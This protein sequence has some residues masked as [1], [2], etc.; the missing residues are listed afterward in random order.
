PFM[1][2]S[3]F[4]ELPKNRNFSHIRHHRAQQFLHEE[5]YSGPRDSITAV[6]LCVD[7]G[8]RK[9]QLANIYGSPAARRYH[10][11]RAV[12]RVVYLAT[13]AVLA[14]AAMMAAPIV[15]DAF[16]RQGRIAQISQDMLQ[17]QIQYDALT[18]EFPETPIP[19]ETMELAVD[20]YELLGS[21]SRSPQQMLSLISAVVSR[22][23]GVAINSVTWA[24]RGVESEVG[25]TQ[26][27]LNDQTRVSFSLFGTLIGSSSI[28]N[29]DRRL[30]A[31]I[32]DLEQIEGA[33]VNP[34]LMP[35]E[36]DPNSEVSALLDDQSFDADFAL[37]INMES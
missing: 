14:I 26:S 19:S 10:E 31:F 32:N 29:S 8:I 22:H 2:D 1:E 17:I 23:P 30:R 12:R 5:D 24:L 16:E 28:Q 9:G 35:I 15:F 4:D 13:A 27:L 7:W 3:D 11:L 36:R 37:S 33:G 6:L 21:Q 18:A 34:I 20:H 25:F